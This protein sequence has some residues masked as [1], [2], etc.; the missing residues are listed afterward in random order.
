M[1]RRRRTD[2]RGNPIIF[3]LPRQRDQRLS[4]PFG[5]SLQQS[6]MTFDVR[7]YFSRSARL[8][9][10]RFSHRCDARLCCRGSR[11]NPASR[12][13]CHGTKGTRNRNPSPYR[14]VPLRAQRLRPHAAGAR[15]T[16]GQSGHR[17][18]EHPQP[19]TEHDLCADRNHSD[20]HQSRHDPGASGGRQS[21]GRKDTPAGPRR[22]AGFRRQ[23]QLSRPQRARQCASPHQRHHAAGRR[24]RLRHV[25]RHRADRQHIADYRRAAGTIRPAHL[26]R[27]RHP[28]PQRCLQRRHGGRLW[29]LAAN[30]HAELRVWR[31]GRSDP[32][33]PHR[34][35]LREQYRT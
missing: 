34:A 20:H 29:R 23:R 17:D 4:R 2:E 8:R 19:G 24:Y 10:L 14:C 12:G 9:A 5:H 31:P 21:N 6:G 15:C 35:V 30:L 18:D 32:V 3:D 7:A 26:G 27:A 28:N 33:F 11:A 1:R 16:A 25:S 13:R 22:D